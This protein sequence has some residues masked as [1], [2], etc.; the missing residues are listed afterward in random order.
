MSGQNRVIT[1][2]KYK[3]H[4]TCTQC[5]VQCTVGSYNNIYSL[6]TVHSPIGTDMTRIHTALLDVRDPQRSHC[7]N[8][9]IRVQYVATG[10]YSLGTGNVLGMRTH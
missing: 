9:N 1:V 5:T 10:A 3:E 7:I 4:N 2:Y 6:F 8:E